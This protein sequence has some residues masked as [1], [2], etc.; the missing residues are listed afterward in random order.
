M[1]ILGQITE[2]GPGHWETHPSKLVR[3]HKHYFDDLVADSCAERRPWHRDLLASWLDENP[4]AVGTGWEPYVVSLRLVNW[5]K[6]W[7]SGVPL[8]DP[9]LKSRLEASAAVQTRWLE[10]RIEHHLLGNHLWTNAKALVFAGTVFH[11]DEA[12]SWLDRG[13]HLLQRELQEQI[14]KD[15]GHF[16]LSPM[17]QAILT[18]DVIDLLQLNGCYPGVLPQGL[19][20]ELS[21]TATRMLHWLRVMTHPDGKV[22][23][24]NDAALNGCVATEHLIEY[25][26]RHSIAT[27]PPSS[28]SL[29]A[30]GY[31]RLQTD[32][33]VV[34]ADVAKV[35][36]D[37]I[38]GH[39]HADT[40]SFEM[41]VGG[42]RLFVNGGTSTYDRGDLREWERSTAA[43][44]TVVVDDS[45]S[46]EVWASF[47]VGRRARPLDIS[48]PE[49][50]ELVLSARHDGY[51]YLPGS[52]THRRRWHLAQ[53]NLTLTDTVE[54]QYRNAH[55][56]LRVHP[57]W[58]VSQTAEEISITNERHLVTLKWTVPGSPPVVADDFWAPGFGS[59]IRC[60]LLRFSVAR[61][62][63]ITVSW[64][65]RT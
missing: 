15:G 26:R 63:T 24:F 35:G 53:D 1:S 31:V 4:P 64:R 19:V 29:K 5:M 27:Q 38:P 52:P 36:P 23:Q 57:S 20:A 39:A 21:T 61:E 47:R 16:E 22:A 9:E 60:T 3:Y 11:G 10:K 46:S 14:L 41:S 6:S 28:E 32:S 65:P 55:A 25:A 42:E 2:V 59:R 56:N 13:L 17:Y 49:E 51:R 54:G 8:A 45:D 12:S 44:N 62:R 30:S 34:L 48:Y 58:S 33:A 40:L 37:Y 7:I 43:H 18:E 50:G